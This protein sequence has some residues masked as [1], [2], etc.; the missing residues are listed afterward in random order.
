MAAAAVRASKGGA[1]L[2]GRVVVRG[3]VGLQIDLASVAGTELVGSAKPTNPGT[4]GVGATLRLRLTRSIADTEIGN[5]EGAGGALA[6]LT[7]APIA[8]TYTTIAVRATSTLQVGVAVV[9][10][11]AHTAAN[12][13]AVNGTG[14]E[15]VVG[16]AVAGAHADPVGVAGGIT[17]AHPALSATPIGPTVAAVAVGG[18]DAGVVGAG[19]TGGTARATR[20]VAARVAALCCWWAARRT[21]TLP[22]TAHQPRQTGATR[23]ATPVVAA[24]LSRTRGPTVTGKGA[25]AV[26]CTF[27][28]GA[29]ATQPT[30]PANTAHTPLTLARDVASAL[31][32]VA[33]G[34]EVR[35]AATR[36]ATQVGATGFAQTLRGAHTGSTVTAPLTARGAGTTRGALQATR[37]EAAGLVEAASGNTAALLGERAGIAGAA[38]AAVAAAAVGATLLARTVGAAGAGVV[39]RTVLPAQAHVAGAAVAA[40]APHAAGPGHTLGAGVAHTLAPHTRVPSPTAPTRPAA[41]VVVSAALLPRTRRLAR[42][43]ERAV[44]VLTAQH[45]RTH[46]TAAPTEA[47]A[48]LALVALHSA[49]TH[50]VEVGAGLASRADTTHST[51]TIAIDPASST[52]T[53]GQTRAFKGGVAKLVS[54]DEG[55]GAAV[56][57]TETNATRATH[58]LSEGITD[59]L[60]TAA[61]VT[62]CTAA[63]RPSAPITAARAC[64][65]VGGALAF[66]RAVAELIAQHL[67]TH[68]TVSAT[69]T[70]TTGAS[71]AL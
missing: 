40:T 2:L 35:A 71:S 66:K 55:A 28:N 18:A 21:H 51:T 16:G 3:D 57:A 23:P 22:S 59:A 38:V 65:A 9:A 19:E 17:A 39:G 70:D 13:A 49:I 64:R 27:N 24:H 67:G 14:G 1:V 56:A 46:P 7:T 4:T 58:A 62:R 42:A 47:Q 45:S 15:G 32:G 44:A 10:H 52:R 41:P 37:V 63:T 61:H 11:E 50:T 34:L 60:G 25:V 69:S 26:L 29:V 20:G 43:L 36:G 54:V 5:T 31:R 8:A 53:A 12:T 48:A 30:T 68:A 6:T 33:A